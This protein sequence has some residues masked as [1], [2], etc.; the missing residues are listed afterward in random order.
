MYIYLTLYLHCYYYIWICLCVRLYVCLFVCL[1]V[2]SIGPEPI[3]YESNLVL[4]CHQDIA[5]LHGVMA[6]LATYILAII[7]CDH[8]V[9]W[10]RDV[11]L[12]VVIYYQ[13]YCDFFSSNSFRFIVMKP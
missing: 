12:R 7:L 8:R 3:V 13:K 2:F 1:I 11:M 10:L 4:P 5:W 6:R 9:A